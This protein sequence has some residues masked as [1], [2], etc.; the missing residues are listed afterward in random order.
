MKKNIHYTSVGQLQSVFTKVK[1]DER[2]NLV[3]NSVKSI[4]VE[5]WN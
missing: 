5:N 4:L 2:K 3:W 1:S